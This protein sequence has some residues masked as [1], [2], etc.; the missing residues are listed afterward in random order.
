M[1]D[2][3]ITAVGP[4]WT[5]DEV[6][7]HLHVDSNDEDALIQA[8]MDASER[9]MLQHCNLTLVPLGQEAVFKAAGFL[10]VAAFYDDRLGD[11]SGIPS[12]AR[13]L[14]APYRWL[15]I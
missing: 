7:A 3:V 4:L 14:I 5:I 6:K 15:T 9:A 1:A 10:T 2:I 11:E 13:H 12:S 8:Y